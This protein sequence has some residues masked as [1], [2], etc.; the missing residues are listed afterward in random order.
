MNVHS[1][2]HID[3]YTQE[4]LYTVQFLQCVNFSRDA[5]TIFGC[6]FEN[7]NS[8]FQRILLFSTKYLSQIDK[9]LMKIN[10]NFNE[11]NE[12]TST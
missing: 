2:G 4:E 10:S 3:C 1:T 7:F 5:K 6:K 12:I 11:C 9:L 8:Y